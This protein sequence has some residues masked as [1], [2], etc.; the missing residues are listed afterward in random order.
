M[1]RPAVPLKLHRL[2]LSGHCHRVELLLSLL[3]LPHEFVDVDLPGGEHRQPAF[4]ALNPL[5]Q[6]PVLQD[7]EHVLPES[8]AILVYLA[9]R[10]APASD[11]LP[12]DPVEAAEQQ[13]WFALS[14]G[15][16]APGPA[17]A[18]FQGIMGRPVPPAMVETSHR[19]FA[20]IEA[21][22]AQR[23]FLVADRPTLADLSFY[24]YTAQAPIGGVSLADYP[25]LRAW[26]AR[27]EAL[28]GFVP[29]PDK[30]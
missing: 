21:H 19:L 16:L 28:P 20:L 30:L 29:L 14:V 9:S 25:R 22:L 11:W 15:M 13:R 2:A 1:T 3:D 7:G 18:R 6:V 27:I 10:Y 4:L 23:P 8:N 26:L 17:S 5:G 24:G 12:R